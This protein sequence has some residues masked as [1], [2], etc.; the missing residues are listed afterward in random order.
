MS[1]TIQLSCKR[2]H[3]EFAA[4]PSEGRVYC[5]KACAYGSLLQQVTNTVRKIPTDTI[6]IPKYSPAKLPR[7]CIN[8]G[9]DISNDRKLAVRCNGC[10]IKKLLEHNLRDGWKTVLVRANQPDSVAT[11]DAQS[12]ERQEAMEAM[13]QR[14]ALITWPTFVWHVLC[15]TW[16]SLRDQEREACLGAACGPEASD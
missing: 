4:R 11:A 9:E 13:R 8:C 7:F 6:Y 3:K 12:R 10:Q 16:R 1:K 15:R 14:D 5:S 2:C